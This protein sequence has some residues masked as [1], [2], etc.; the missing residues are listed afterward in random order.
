MPILPAE[1]E[2]YPA[3]LWQGE[4]PKADS[5][6]WWCLHTKPRQEKMAARV[7]Q[8]RR[9]CHYLPQV[10][11]VQR[12]PSGRK[13][14]SLIP[15]FPGYLFLHGDDYQRVE[16]NHGNHLANVLEVPDQEAL[17]RDL[18][19]VHRMLSS[20]VPICPE[21]TFVVGDKVR[22]LSGP[23]SGIVGTVIR[24]DGR[25]RFLATVN[26]LGRG[27]TIELQDWQVE[28]VNDGR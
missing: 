15:L 6:R 18:R 8:K 7:L 24:R 26:F 25:D 2:M 16:A 13:I 12:T 10:K 19:Q 22:I 17:E 27:A 5:H 11:R 20:G 1:P 3:H 28:P 21:P 14:Q 23:L 9:I 4:V